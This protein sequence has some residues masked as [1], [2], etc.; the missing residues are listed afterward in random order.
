MRACGRAC[1]RASE[2]IYFY[3]ILI[4]SAMSDSDMEVCSD[5]INYYVNSCLRASSN[6]RS[7][8]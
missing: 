8:M 6:T 1:M 3:E 7:S 2:V 4:I 5:L